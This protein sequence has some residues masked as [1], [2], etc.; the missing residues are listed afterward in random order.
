MTLATI[1]MTALFTGFH[2]LT[3]LQEHFLIQRN[4][5]FWGM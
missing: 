5:A 1:G 2:V 3:L 4:I